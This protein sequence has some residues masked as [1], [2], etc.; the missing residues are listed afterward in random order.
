MDEPIS[1]SGGKIVHLLFGIPC[2]NEM[3]AGGWETGSLCEKGNWVEVAYPASSVNGT[4]L[5]GL[6]RQRVRK[7]SP[8]RETIGRVAPRNPP[9]TVLTIRGIM[10]SVVDE[11]KCIDTMVENMHCKSC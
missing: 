10:W 1:G 3:F 6:L 9:R 8:L 7:D 2:I 4:V 11:C 5:V